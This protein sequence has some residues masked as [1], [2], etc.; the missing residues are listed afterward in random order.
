MQTGGSPRTH[1]CVPARSIPR[2]GTF[3][4]ARF[5]GAP[6]VA[7]SWHPALGSSVRSRCRALTGATSA[8]P[9]TASHLNRHRKPHGASPIATRSDQTTSAPRLSTHGTGPR[10]S[11]RSGC[12]RILS[13]TTP[14]RCCLHRRVSATNAVVANHHYV[15]CLSGVGAGKGNLNLPLLCLWAAGPRA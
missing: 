6:R 9:T 10:I 1:A 7:H 5:F 3:S 15:S 12:I 8:P 11:R 2:E 14:L 4:F 13:P